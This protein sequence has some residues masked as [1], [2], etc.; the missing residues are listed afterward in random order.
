MSVVPRRTEHTSSWDSA[1]LL[2][3]S[4]RPCRI[5][6][7][8]KDVKHGTISI[9]GCA[10]THSFVAGTVDWYLC[11]TCNSQGWQPP[12][13]ANGDYVNFRVSPPQSRSIH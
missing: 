11:V 5:C 3:K 9:R 7:G 6:N 1:T 13:T 4:I 2:K 12:R 10:T 8:C